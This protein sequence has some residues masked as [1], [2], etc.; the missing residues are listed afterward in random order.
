MIFRRI[1]FCDSVRAGRT[2]GILLALAGGLARV[3]LCHAAEEG[4]L[5]PEL[6][7]AIPWKAIGVIAACLVGLGL[8]A[9]KN[10]RRT[11]QESGG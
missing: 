10:S 5:A 2:L 1:P 6:E 7:S 3:G 11:S 4:Y 8:S 9:L